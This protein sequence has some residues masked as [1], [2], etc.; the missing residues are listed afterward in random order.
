MVC[1][2]ERRIINLILSMLYSVRIR[3][4]YID[5]LLLLDYTLSILIFY[6]S[7]VTSLVVSFHLDTFAFV[8]VIFLYHF[9][10]CI[11]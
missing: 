6:M 1:G 8:G 9:H 3:F 5:L 11:T 7:P 2:C 10:R 4:T